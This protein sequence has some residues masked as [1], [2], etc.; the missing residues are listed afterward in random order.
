MIPLSLAGPASADP[1]TDALANTTCSYAQVTAALDAQA[2]VLAKQ[3]SYRPD[4]QRNLQ[5]FLAMP[6]DQRQQS[7]AQQQA[8]NPQLQAILAAQIGPQVVQVANTC[9]NY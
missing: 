9:M 2:P 5:Q 1:I 7:I 6:V 4:M 8:A 3:L